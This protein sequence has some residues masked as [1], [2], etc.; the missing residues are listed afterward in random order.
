MDIGRIE[1][2]NVTAFFEAQRRL[3]RVN[4][5]GSLDADVAIVVYDWI[6][7]VI[8]VIGI[9]NIYGEIFDFRAVVEFQ[10]DNLLAARRKSRRMNLRM[11]VHTFP[12]A[13]IVKNFYHEEILRGPMQNVPENKRRIIVYNEEDALKFIDEWHKNNG[14]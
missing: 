10:P 8:S 1:Q 13:M 3:I 11:P 7:K 12:V 4:Y 9:E 6:D 2:D 14:K 5:R